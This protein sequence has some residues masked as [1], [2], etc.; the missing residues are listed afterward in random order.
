[1]GHLMAFSCSAYLYEGHD[2]KHPQND[3][4]N[5]AQ[6]ASLLKQYGNANQLSQG[7]LLHAQLRLHEHDHSTFIGNCLVEM[8]GSCGSVKEAQATFDNISS[9]NAH[10]WNIL[11][12][13]YAE[14]DFLEDAQAV[15]DRM[16]DP[17]IYSWNTILKAY[18]KS[19][20]LHRAHDVFRDMPSR[21]VVSWTAMLTALS[22]HG[23]SK[24]SLQLFHEMQSQC[25][26]PNKVT[27][28]CAL[29]ACTDQGDLTE[30]QAIHT[31][32]VGTHYVSNVEVGNALIDMYGKCKSLED[33]KIVFGKMRH[34]DIV[35]YNAMLGALVDNESC[36]EALNFCSQFQQEDVCADEITYLCGL[37]A[38]ASLGVPEVGEQVHSKIVCT[39]YDQDE[40]VGSALVSMYGKCGS[41]CHALS[42]FGTIHDKDVVSWNA[43]I[44]ALF[45]NGQGPEALEFFSDMHAQGFKPNKTTIVCVSNAC[46]SVGNLAQGQ[47]LHALIVEMGFAEHLM[48]G[49]ALVDMY[50]KCKSPADAKI[51]FD[52]MHDHDVISWNALIAA[53]AQNSM[54]KEAL[55][56]F[57]CMQC[58]GVK[59][60]NVTFVSSLSACAIAADLKTGQEMHTTIESTNYITDTLVAN[61]LVHM[62][63]KCGSMS[64]A[65]ALFDRIPH[66][67]VTSW[68]VLLSVLSEHGNGQE[69]LDLFH[70]MELEAIQPDIISFI[71][72]LDA[73]A[74]MNALEDGQYIHR[75][76]IV[77][78]REQ[79]MVLENS[80]ISLYVNCGAVDEAHDA[81]SNMPHFNVISWNM[82]IAAFSQ[83][84]Y[85]EEVFDYYKRMQGENVM[86][87]AITYMCI[88]TSCARKT[89]PE[90]GNRIHAI[91]ID[92]GFLRDVMV[93][94]ALVSMYGKC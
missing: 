1:M 7:R 14:N 71:C 41:V 55:D 78:G 85:S 13:A 12:N 87:D 86:A 20:N 59:G 91:I 48:V 33:A 40:V 76:I 43:I 47:S 77:S 19:G 92:E 64:N 34:R 74:A 68:N 50:G 15:F 81:F 8:Y 35:T 28:V 45:Q 56:I 18:S 57:H 36:E 2:I 75:A 17:N 52:Q 30:G 37:N 26:E 23:H 79:D 32:I 54:G 58:K 27:F 44:S 42:V 62:Y 89:A 90:E 60:D 11:M 3:T 67:D 22:K 82:I 53:F 83:R 65:R 88:L 5:Y 16:Q 4:A 72:V 70:Q 24:E 29:N 21:D 63:G 80:L 38:C 49:N 84:G 51:I 10:S 73:C 69:V 93:G 25:V 66:R 46:A 39:G 61:A 31:M 6:F 9:P 94:N